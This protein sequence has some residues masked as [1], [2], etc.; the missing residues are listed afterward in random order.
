M[1]WFYLSFF[2]HLAAFLL[3]PAVLWHVGHFQSQVAFH[4]RLMT[5]GH[6][7]MSSQSQVQS[8]EYSKI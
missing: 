1:G 7:N 4:P 5:T 8:S 6:K 3:V 2:P